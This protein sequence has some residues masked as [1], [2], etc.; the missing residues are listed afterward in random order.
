MP[1]VA[2]KLTPTHSGGFVARKRIPEDAQNEYV[3]LY[4]VQ[5]EA[6]F[7]A[8]PGTPIMLARAKHREWLTEVESRIANI[9]AQRNGEGL[10]LTPKDARALAGD[11]Y[12]WFLERQRARPQT[13]EHWEFFREQICDA[14]ADALDPYRDP[15]DPDLHQRDDVWENIPRA[16]EDLRPMLED[17]CETAQFLAARKLVLDRSSREMFLDALYGDFAA[18]LDLQIRNAR[19]D[20]TPDTYPLRFP[21]SRESIILVSRRGYCSSDGLQGRSRRKPQ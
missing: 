10:S 20:Y 12:G 16:R 11:W 9:R 15:H 21:N 4:G 6:R 1:R 3:R 2:T 18:V 14:M 7:R 19:G 5:W 13:A 17:W 8:P